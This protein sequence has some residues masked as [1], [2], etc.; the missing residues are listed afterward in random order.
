MVGHRVS[1][2]DASHSLFKPARTD[3]SADVDVKMTESKDS[4]STDTTASTPAALSAS[5]STSSTTSHTGDK[6]AAGTLL[7][8]PGFAEITREV[9][10]VTVA[11]CKGVKYLADLGVGVV[12]ETSTVASLARKIHDRVAKRLHL[13]PSSQS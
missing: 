8:I 12:C 6:S 13:I 2:Q 7:P 3:T 1:I 9:V 4:I 10:A 11:E 5:T